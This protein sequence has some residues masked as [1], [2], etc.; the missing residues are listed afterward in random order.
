MYRLSTTMAQIADICHVIIGYT[1]LLQQ[2]KVWRVNAFQWGGCWMF[3]T[4]QNQNYAPESTPEGKGKAKWALFSQVA[5]ILP[6]D[7]FSS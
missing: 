3:K 4:H 1:E 5:F 7:S 6:L 2:N